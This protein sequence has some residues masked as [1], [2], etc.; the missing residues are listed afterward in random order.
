[1]KYKVIIVAYNG[2]VPSN[3]SSLTSHSFYT[4]VQATQFCEAWRQI[5]SS[6][7]AYLWDGSN[8]VQYA[9]IP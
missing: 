9:P 3:G 6:T 7:T 1:M 8:M 2:T 5:G 4:R